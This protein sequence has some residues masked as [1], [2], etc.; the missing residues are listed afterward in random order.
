VTLKPSSLRV[1]FALL[2]GATL[3]IGML[4]LRLLRHEE[5][6]LA[7]E[8]RRTLQGRAQLVADDLQLAVR[9]V[10]EEVL[11][12]LA[13][14]P[15]G[16]LSRALAGWPEANPLVRNTFIWNQAARRLEQPSPTA[17]TTAEE[18]RFI[19]RYSHLF[20]ARLDTLLRAGEREDAALLAQASPRMQL[21]RVAQQVKALPSAQPVR[22]GWI[23]WFEGDQLFL[24]GW[25]EQ[26]GR[27]AGV[28]LETA[29]LLSRLLQV[30]PREA[31]TDRAWALL[32]GAGNLLHQTGGL[33][34]GKGRTPAVA[35]SLSPSLPHWQVA[36]FGT[37]V[38][39]AA[40]GGYRLIT[41]LLV[42]ALL[43]SILA[44]GTLLL[45]EAGRKAREARQK[46]SFVA[47]V[48]HELKTPLT[49]LRMYA[50]LLR[51]G[52]V[53]APEQ[54]QHYLDVMVTECARL[55]RLV[56]NM[57]D[58]GRLEQQRRTY[59]V[60][61][62][63][64]AAWLPTF[65]EA[66]RLRIEEAGLRLAVKLPGA[67]LSVRIDRDALEQAVLNLLDNALKYAADGKQIEIV[68]TATT[69]SGAQLEVNDRGPGVPE[70][71]REK[72]FE[73]FYRLDQSL[74]A[75]VPGSGLGLSI[76]RRLLRD[77]G[78]DL[79]CLPRE[80]GGACFRIHLKGAL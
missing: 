54:R 78:G 1:G 58:F 14:L 20:A 64:L 36:F 32:D 31:G 72:I 46:T 27:V 42:G 3:A 37:G 30:F 55:T 76:A 45:L 63:D 53:R 24:L 67:P 38:P 23:P 73:K 21:N 22:R 10:Q 28:E 44:G 40:A 80:G 75:R 25:V 43:L 71:L 61:P 41:T 5:T 39:A 47:N 35:A 26:H 68:L 15:P 79:V 29:A 13:A 66:Q 57:L 7:D 34:I 6:R 65:L 16:D 12:R 2:V 50:E 70:E 69:G 60:E 52:R 8:A 56:N 77:L 51:E 62:L 59:A 9:D 18:K 17:P 11:N 19:L 33:D 74:T 48:S 49:T 4:S